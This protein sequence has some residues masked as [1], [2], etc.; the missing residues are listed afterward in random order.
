MKQL[1]NLLSAARLAIAPWV[2]YLILHDE[3]P[4]VLVWFFLAGGTDA[5]DGWLA[6]RLNAASA[7]GQALDPIA[8]KV[9]LSGVYV[10]LALQSAIPAWLAWMVLGRDALILLFAAAVLAFT[11]TRLS[12]P[13]SIWGKL[14]TIAQ[15]GFVVAVVI[16]RAGFGLPVSV[17]LWIPAALTV[18][19]GIDYAR[20]AG[21]GSGPKKESH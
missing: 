20:R 17:L 11:N 15:M 9:L 4:A 2:I 16:D 14:S 7:L 6:R 21:L 13:P 1:P 3:Y 5:L 19:S 12:F 8:D 18:W 10:A